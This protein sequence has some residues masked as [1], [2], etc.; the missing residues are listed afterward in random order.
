M[1]AARP[2]RFRVRDAMAEDAAA[3]DGLLRRAFA[4]GEDA[5]HG[6]RQAL[7]DGLAI[8]LQTGHR[9]LVAEEGDAFAGLVRWWA[10]DGEAWFDLLAAAVPGAGRELVRAVERAAQDRG[11][12]S[13]RA[14]VPQG[15]ELQDLASWWGYYPVRGATPGGVAAQVVVEK[16]LPLL[17][18]RAQRRNDAQAIAALADEDPWPFE[19]GAR[20]GWF[21]LADGDRVAG[22]VSGKVGRDGVVRIAEP[23]LAPG[24]R[25]RGLEV[26]MAAR[27]ALWAST[28]GAFRAEVA[29]SPVLEQYERDF[30]ERR[31]HREGEAF[32]LQLTAPGLD[33][34]MED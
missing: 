13:A 15:S 33:R 17:T 19:Q 22:V 3:G 28:E 14:M 20:P 1:A 30:E 23:L 27:V 5:L 6:A 34:P 16:R 24:Y 8:L 10:E 12:R 11:L 31:W 26:W 29:A 7:D 18:V 9:F 32:A 2:S 4:G 25:G 21:V